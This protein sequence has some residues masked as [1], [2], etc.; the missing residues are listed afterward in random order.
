MKMIFF[1]EKC[2][3][4]RIWKVFQISAA[5]QPM[6]FVESIHKSENWT[7]LIN[8]FDGQLAILKWAVTRNKGNHVCLVM[9][10][11]INF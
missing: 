2:S 3:W 8:N 11:S 7:N 5:S 1:I 9:W 4:A 10:R 6:S